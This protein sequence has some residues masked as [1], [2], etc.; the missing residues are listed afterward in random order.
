M[1]EETFWLA[2]AL[3][4]GKSSSVYSPALMSPWTD[5]MTE[6]TFWLAMAVLICL[7]PSSIVPWIGFMTEETF[8]LAMALMSSKSSTV[9]SPALMSP[10]TDLMTEET[11]WLAMALMSGKSSSVYSPVLLFPLTRKSD[12]G[13][14]KQQRLKPTCAMWIHVVWSVPLLFTI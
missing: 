6:E 7:L 5:F 1:T 12:F 13:V 11:F 9:Y 2:M 3:M 8:W 10:W 14:C 4:S